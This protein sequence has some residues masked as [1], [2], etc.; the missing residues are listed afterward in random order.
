MREPR[1]SLSQAFLAER[2]QQLAQ[3]NGARLRVWP[4]PSRISLP[5][6]AAELERA[7][8]IRSSQTSR[9]VIA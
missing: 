8:A 5:Q 1:P 2:V 3:R 9:T 7:A 4:F 6:K